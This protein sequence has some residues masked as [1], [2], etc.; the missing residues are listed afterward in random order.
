MLVFLVAVHRASEEEYGVVAVESRRS[1]R[2]AQL[3]E[4]VT[5]L[6]NER[7][8]ELASGVPGMDYR[9][10]LHAGSLCSAAGGDAV[11]VEE[12]AQLEGVRSRLRDAPERVL[13]ILRRGVVVEERV[14]LL[15]LA[16]EL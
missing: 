14:G 6:A 15:R 13:R 7:T 10:D 11:H 5:E 9:E 12:P 16:G 3:V 4:R 1:V 2:E 8:E